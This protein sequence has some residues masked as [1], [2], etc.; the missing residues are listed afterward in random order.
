VIASVS[1]PALPAGGLQPTGTLICTADYT[2]T[3]A[4][5]DAGGVTN[6][7]SASDGTTT[8]GPDSVTVD[9]DITDGLSIVKRA[10]TEG[11]AMPGD[12]VSYE[13][14]VTNIGNA[15]L[16]AAI[17]V[18]DDKIANVTCPALPAGGLL[19]QAVLTC[20]ADYEVTQ[21]DIDAG[22]VTNIASASSGSVTSPEA[23][24]T[25]EGSVE[26]RLTITKDAS[27]LVQAFGPIYDV[28]YTIDVENTGNVTL[29]NFQV[30]DDLQAALAPSI[31]FDT[32]VVTVSNIAGATANAGY[33]GAA[34]TGLLSGTPVLNVGDSG[35]ITILVRVDTSNGAPAQPNTATSESAEITA[36]VPSNPAIIEPADQD[37]DG[38]PDNFESST[39]DRDGDGIPDSEDY[40]PT[41]YFYCEENGAI[42]TGGG[43]SVLGPNGVNNAIGTAND[44]VI[45]RDGSDGYFQFY[46]T[47]PGSYTLIPDYPLT[48]VASTDRQVQTVALDATSLL[49]DNPAILGS[50]EFGNSGELADASLE[51]NPKFYFEF[52]FEAGDPAILMN[53]IPLKHCGSSELS[54]AKSVIGE[55]ITQEDGRQLVTYEFNIANSGQTLVNDIQITDDL[56]DVYGDANVV[57][58]RNEIMA[59]PQGFAGN[60]NTAYDGVTD[61]TVLDGLGSLEAGEAMTVQLEALVTPETA[62]S[63]INKAT[64]QGANPLTGDAVAADDT[65]SIDLIPAA[66]VNDLIVRKTARPRTV[67]IGDPVLYTIDV[68]NSGIGTIS[69]I[70][71]VDDIP[72]GF[73]YIP[74]SASIS[75]GVSS[76][77]LEPVVAGRSSLS[78]SLQTGNAAPLD[79]LAPGET[80]SV[81]LRLLAGPNVEFGAHEN[82]AYAENRDTGERSDIATAIVDYILYACYWPRL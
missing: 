3:Q 29:T 41:G 59:E 24:V 77:N 20:S 75:D 33:D 70:D 48:G 71:I 37:G 8:S 21:D 32:P 16:T 30:S 1:C 44:I 13:Y 9:A 4:D 18:A 38:A 49:P 45:V 17:D 35:V 31:I 67:Q 82:Q 76:V 57:I 28:T 81:N 34:D 60:E 53:N 27:E 22:S 43:I 69:N 15:T 12:I 40:D 23:T 78:W 46:V 56:G 66:K 54:L 58:N 2:V 11:F 42:L 5:I 62:S 36:P 64:A 79:Y 65:A 74:N 7:A 26:P 47:A 55:P 6:I 19:P 10:V 80:I 63:F 61:I 14:D 72:A 50:S 39:E 25:V 51:A 68:T 52:D 73:A